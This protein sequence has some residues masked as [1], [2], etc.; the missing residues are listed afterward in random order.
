[1][2]LLLSI[3]SDIMIFR[4]LFTLGFV[5]AID[6]YAY[7]AFKT[8]F[9][10]SATPWI[11]WGITIAYIIFSIYMS[12][13][14]TSGKVDYKYLSLLVG[15]TILIAVPKM[16]IMAPLIIEDIFR[17]GNSS[18]A[19]SLH[20]RQSCQSVGPLSLNSHLVLPLYP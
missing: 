7:Q 8:V 6:F 11:Y 14:M 20:S 10:S 9:K 1:M 3:Q 19:Q 18:F 16:V 2:A 4:I 5:L 15:T 17:L 13:M 12:L